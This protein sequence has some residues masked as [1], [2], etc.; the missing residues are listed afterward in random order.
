[1]VYGTVKVRPL[2]A[3]IGDRLA[4]AGQGAFVI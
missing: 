4:S 3:M 1:M 2:L